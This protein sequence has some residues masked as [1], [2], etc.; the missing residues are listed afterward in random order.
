MRSLFND[1]KIVK[2]EQT[3][4]ENMKLFALGLTAIALLPLPA[5]AKPYS[6]PTN[7]PV[8]YMITSQGRLIDLTRMCGGDR[9]Q[10]SQ[11]QP[12]YK[13]T[14]DDICAEF[15]RRWLSATNQFQADEAKKGLDLCENNR[16][17]IQR[18]TG[19]IK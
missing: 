9:A 1:K 11:I 8:C 15:A 3:W 6:E 5:I 7:A 18:T 13:V 19:E 2:S 4:I 12:E 16:A 14:A 17:S 10:I